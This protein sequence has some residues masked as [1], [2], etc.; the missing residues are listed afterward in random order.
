MKN[1]NEKARKIHRAIEICAHVVW[2]IG[3]I[4]VGLLILTTGAIIVAI[5]MKPEEGQETLAG[6]GIVLVIVATAGLW[7]CLKCVR[8]D[9]DDPN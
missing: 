4:V 6:F 9:S 3:I 7:L 5:M 8:G 1:K 2:W